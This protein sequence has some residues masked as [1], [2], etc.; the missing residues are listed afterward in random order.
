[1]MQKKTFNKIAYTLATLQFN[2]WAEELGKKVDEAMNTA[3]NIDNRLSM[4]TKQ[5]IFDNF[6][7]VI[8]ADDKF[9]RY[10]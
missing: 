2:E 1:M 8:K 6:V 4:K 9:K 3:L 7:S 5:K 10:V